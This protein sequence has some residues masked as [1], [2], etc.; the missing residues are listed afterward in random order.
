MDLSF[1]I[2]Y[3]NDIDKAREIILDEIKSTPEAF[4]DPEPKVYVAAHKDSAITLQMQ[5]WTKSENYWPI[6]YRLLETVKK[7][8]DRNDISIPYPQV[9]IHVA[10]E[11][12]E[13]VKKNDKSS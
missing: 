1:G 3:E 2:A 8:F 9:D 12:A 5:V 11:T 6:H 4:L 13:I 7:A 10:P